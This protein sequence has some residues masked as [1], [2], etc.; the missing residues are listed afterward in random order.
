MRL[1]SFIV[2]G[3]AALA[4]AG[5]AVTVYPSLASTE[6]ATK[7]AVVDAR[8]EPPMVATVD[9]KRIGASER[10]FTGSV[11][12]RIQSNL[13][14]RVPGKI[15]ER[16][17]DAGEEVKAG[18]PL[19]RVDDR[20]LRLALTAKLKAVDAARALAVQARADE[21]RYASLLRLGQA[22]R[23]RYEQ[24]KA[25]LDTAEGQLSAAEAEADVARNEADYAVLVADADGSVVETLGEP[26]QVVSAGQAVVRL[27]HDGQR[28]A[29]VSL[30][31]TVRPGIGAAAEASIYGLG[32]RRWPAVLRQLSSAADVQT[33]TYEAR[34]VLGGDAA[35]APIGSTVTVWIK[36]PVAARSAEVPIG[37]ILDENGTTGVWVVDRASSKVNLRPVTILELGEETATVSGLEPGT[38]VA[39]LGAHLLH[40]GAAIRL[41]AAKGF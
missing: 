33:R 26:G 18:Q 22:P 36:D 31:E 5:A 2:L 16:L 23:Q 20:D 10:A 13:G 37:A 25:T 1:V 29:T 24:A 7:P 40:E 32:D 12:A 27:A 8:S 35:A 11:S 3:S 15:V 38:P 9:A 4:A 28:E 39:A 21:A 41:L 14:F 6:E 34:F 17:V 19:M 30:P